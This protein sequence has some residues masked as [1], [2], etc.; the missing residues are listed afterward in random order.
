LSRITGYNFR[1]AAQEYIQRRRRAAQTRRQFLLEDWRFKAGLPQKHEI[2]RPI[3]ERRNGVDGQGA[4]GV[5][6]SELHP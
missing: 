3:L 6:R 5:N 2:A 4:G 1:T